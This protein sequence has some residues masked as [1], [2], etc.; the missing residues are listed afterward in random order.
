MSVRSRC[1]LCIVHR[2]FIDQA[3]QHGSRR[4][5]RMILAQTPL[6]KIDERGKLRIGRLALLHQLTHAFIGCLA[7]C[8]QLAQAHV[9]RPAVLREIGEARVG[10]L[11]VLREIVQARIGAVLRLDQALDSLRQALDVAALAL[12][13]IHQVAHG[14]KRVPGDYRIVTRDTTRS[15]LTR[16]PDIG[17]WTAEAQALNGQRLSPSPRQHSLWLDDDVQ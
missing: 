5:R 2:A 16:M 17:P 8:C 15:G 12:H 6:E 4:A 9:G 10:R 11:A 13:G 7:L 3:P 14:G 1:A